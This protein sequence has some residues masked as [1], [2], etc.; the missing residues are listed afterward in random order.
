VEVTKKLTNEIAA[1]LLREMLSEEEIKKRIA[2]AHRA[3]NAV[4]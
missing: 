4:D 2:K 1:G 3:K